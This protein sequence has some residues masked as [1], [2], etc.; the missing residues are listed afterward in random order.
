MIYKDV[1]IVDSGPLPSTGHHSQRSFKKVSTSQGCHAP[2]THIMYKR[3][4]R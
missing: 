2:I 4:D 1:P 3:A